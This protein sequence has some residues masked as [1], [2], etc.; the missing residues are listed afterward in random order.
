[1]TYLT[2]PPPADNGEHP[3]L[4]PAEDRR[5]GRRVAGKETH[6]SCYFR[7][8]AEPG[9]RKALLQITE[10]CDLKCAH[11][12]VSATHAGDDMSVSD[13]QVAFGR[14]EAARVSHVTLTGGEPFVHPNLIEIVELLAERH[15]SITICTNAVSV[16]QEQIQSLRRH[17]CVSV[18]VSLDGFSA[19]S[20]GRF[21]GDPGSF[22]VTKANTEKLAEAGLL[23][24]VL[25]TPNA[26]A[27][28]SEYTEIY[29]FADRLEAEYVL[30]NPLSSFGR[31]IR[32]RRRL[33][34]D[35]AAMRT[36]KSNVNQAAQSPGGPEPVFIRFPNDDQPLSGCIAGDIVYIFVNGDTAV[37]PYLVF[38]TSNPGSQ[39]TAEEFMAANLFRDH[40]FATKLDAY[41]FHDRYRVPDNTTCSSC[42]INGSCGSGC[43]AAIVAAGGRI[44][45]LDVDV[46]PLPTK[47]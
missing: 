32:T 39:H 1:M 28:P 44:G 18:N 21:R 4:R 14:L 7:S 24:G 23:K 40:D 37:C 47:P 5:G 16:T 35:D 13:M 41:D 3:D 42:A 31:G 22:E 38:A 29:R 26:F 12:F 20:H 33:R 30:M 10:R 25:C 6:N 2:G 45:D 11:C 15:F 27:E 43:P 46:C 8:G 9:R 17:D 19:D 34:A 36:I